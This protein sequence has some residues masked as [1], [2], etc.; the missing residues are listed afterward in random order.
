MNET[1][2]LRNLQS[3]AERLGVAVAMG[4]SDNLN[5]IAIELSILISD[6]E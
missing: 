6:I 4:E 5:N 1:N 3:T 2:R